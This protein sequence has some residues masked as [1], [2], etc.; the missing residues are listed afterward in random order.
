MS[1]V[2][3]LAWR[4]CRTMLSLLS[5][6]LA[7]AAAP[8]ALQP[9]DLHLPRP[10]RNLWCR[11]SWAGVGVGLLC[12]I[13]LLF[14]WPLDGPTWLA[15]TAA[16][17]AC[18]TLR[19]CMAALAGAAPVVPT[20]RGKATAPTRPA[21]RR[22]PPEPLS[23]EAHRSTLREATAWATAEVPL[24]ECSDADIT[25]TYYYR[26]RVFWLHLKRDVRYGYTLSEFLPRVGWSGPFGT[27]NCPFGHQAAEGRWLRR[28]DVMDNYSLFWFRH[29]QADRRYT[30]WPAHAAHARYKLDGRRGA[31]A[32][33]L[34][35]L[36]TEYARWVNRSWARTQV[37]M[38]T[39][40]L[41]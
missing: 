5:G 21:L 29:P 2:F 11:C 25:T 39:L 34:P 4:R 40:T 16:V 15:S 9:R 18:A 37:P 17:P 32:A 10:A 3:L 30:W 14:S 20:A 8:A 23:A 1:R 38:L 27:I 6:L 12:G 33:L 28:P 36:R 7:S 13:A 24:F 41:P 19:T 31:V 22:P 26:W 35:H